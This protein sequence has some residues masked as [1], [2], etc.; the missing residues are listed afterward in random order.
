MTKFSQVLHKEK[1]IKILPQIVYSNLFLTYVKLNLFCQ[2][3]QLIE[4]ILLFYSIKAAIY[5]HSPTN[6]RYGFSLKYSKTY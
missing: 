1:T 5:I 6:I 3:L 2:K 4:H